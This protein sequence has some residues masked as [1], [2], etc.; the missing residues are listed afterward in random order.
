MLLEALR[1]CAHSCQALR[2]PSACCMRGPITSSGAHIR[3]RTGMAI[4]R[5]I[6]SLL[7][8]PIPPCGQSAVMLLNT[9][10]LDFHTL[11]CAVVWEGV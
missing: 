8:L 2:Y 1:L 7:C 11:S 9:V 5:Q 4:R 3:T 6:L 10:L